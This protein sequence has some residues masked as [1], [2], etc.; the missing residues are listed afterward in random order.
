MRLELPAAWK[1]RTDPNSADLAAMQGTLVGRTAVAPARIWALGATAAGT[2]T[3]ELNRLM[4][5][6]N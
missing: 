4:F 2:V 5:A 1:P 6:S 3:V